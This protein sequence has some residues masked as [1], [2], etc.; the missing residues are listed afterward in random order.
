[1]SLH[2][3]L[4]L[5]DGIV[6]QSTPSNPFRLAAAGG[7]SLL[8]PVH[9]PDPEPVRPLL[10]TAEPARRGLAGQGERL[11]WPKPIWRAPNCRPDGAAPEASRR[12]ALQTGGSYVGEFDATPSARLVGCAAA[13]ETDPPR[14]AIPLQTAAPLPKAPRR[15][16]RSGN[17]FAPSGA[18]GR[19]LR[20]L[21]KLGQS[22]RLELSIICMKK[23]SCILHVEDDENDILLL[24]LAFK[25][26]GITNPVQV[27]N[28]GQQAI[29]Y[30]ARVGAYA[31]RTKFPVPSLVLL[32]LN[33]PK[34]PGLEV[35]EWIRDQPALKS[36]AVI[37]FS[38]WAR[39]ADMERASKVGSNSYFLKP[40]DIHQYWEFAKRLKDSWL[41]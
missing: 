29:D 7:W 35:L 37:V 1:M 14:R 6:F 2:C 17:P 8:L 13:L 22:S 18:T 11:G 26:A 9:P 27:V 39:K 5:N 23:N 21:T 12:K 15:P 28:D 16:F 19:D 24:S 31:D 25:Q 34:K 36:L 20:D 32:D 30:L 40:M 10:E 41:E 38:S 4:T 3:W 33:L